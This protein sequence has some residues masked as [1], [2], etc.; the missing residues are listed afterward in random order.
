MQNGQNEDTIKILIIK[1]QDFLILN[2]CYH[3]QRVL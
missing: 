1:F 3:R 2:A